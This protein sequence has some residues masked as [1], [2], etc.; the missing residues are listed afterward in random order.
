MTYNVFGGML[1]IA[2]LNF[3]DS[4]PNNESSVSLTSSVPLCRARPF[5]WICCANFA[6]YRIGTHGWI[7]VYII[8]VL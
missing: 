4:C 7:C 1:N 3:A 2:Q 5:C 8:D 6:K